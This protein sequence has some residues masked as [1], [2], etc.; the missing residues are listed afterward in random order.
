VKDKGQPVRHLLERM[1]I[2]PERAA[3]IGNS[4]QDARMFEECGFGVAFH[5]LDDEVR[6]AADVVIEEPDLALAIGPLTRPR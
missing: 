5:P 2:A 6:E 1:R 3:A 4:G